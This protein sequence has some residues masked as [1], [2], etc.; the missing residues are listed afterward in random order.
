MTKNRLP[1]YSRWYGKKESLQS[2]VPILLSQ[3]AEYAAMGSYL[4]EQFDNCLVLG[5]DNNIMGDFYSFKKIIPTIYLKRV[6]C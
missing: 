2:Y 1:L 4:A 5:A 3:G 6:Y